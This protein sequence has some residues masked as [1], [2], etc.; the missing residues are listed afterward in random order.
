MSQIFY[1]VGKVKTQTKTQSVW[2]WNLVEG[3]KTQLKIKQVE[4]RKRQERRA[5][6]SHREIRKQ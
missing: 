2:K 1:N 3:S 6:A 4:N 5:S